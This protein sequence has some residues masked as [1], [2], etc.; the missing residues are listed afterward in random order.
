MS[1]AKGSL[2]DSRVHAPTTHPHTLCLD[3][4]AMLQEGSSLLRMPCQVSPVID[5]NPEPLWQGCRA[6]PLQKV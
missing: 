6:Q 2:R 4:G 3:Q 5:L 1:P